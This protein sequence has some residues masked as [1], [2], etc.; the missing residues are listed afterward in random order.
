M[1]AQFATQ[2]QISKVLPSAPL[3]EVVKPASSMGG[4]WFWR[5]FMPPATGGACAE[6]S[7]TPP[8][9]LLAALLG[10]ATCGSSMLAGLLLGAAASGAP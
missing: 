5:G 8:P 3:P 6:A 10:A 4:A 7:T 1:T 2:A 9:S